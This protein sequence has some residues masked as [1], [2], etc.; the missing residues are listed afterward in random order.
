MRILYYIRTFGHNIK[1]EY[2]LVFPKCER[3]S[4]EIEY[5]VHIFLIEFFVQNKYIIIECT[6]KDHPN[7]EG[8]SFWETYSMQWPLWCIQLLIIKFWLLKNFQV[9]CSTWAQWLIVYG[10]THAVL[11]QIV[12]EPRRQILHPIKFNR[13][14]SFSNVYIWFYLILNI[15]Q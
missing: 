6:S 4:Q 13:Y 3:T 5:V 12:H 15:K 2:S 9:V 8:Y 7:I 11:K 1:T 14:K 10:A